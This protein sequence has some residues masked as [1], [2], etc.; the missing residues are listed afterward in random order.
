[1]VRRTTGVALGNP[2]QSFAARQGPFPG[3]LCASGKHRVAGA[4]VEETTSAT[5]E[6]CDD[7]M[8]ERSVQAATHITQLHHLLPTHQFHFSCTLHRNSLSYRS[9]C[10]VRHGVEAGILID[11]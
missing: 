2:A 5:A 7:D 3:P 11:G 8:D 6:L 9:A 1:V 4:L 10:H